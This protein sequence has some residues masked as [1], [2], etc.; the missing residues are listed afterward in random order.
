[1][2]LASNIIWGILLITP[3]VIKNNLLVRHTGYTNNKY[4]IGKKFFNCCFLTDVLAQ[5]D[6]YSNK[7]INPKV[8][9]S[10]YTQSKHFIEIYTKDYC[11]Y[12]DRAIDLFNKKNVSFTEINLSEHPELKDR[13]IDRSHRKTVPQ[14]FI[15]HQHIGGCDDLYE[16]ESAGKLDLLLS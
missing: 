7:K 3:L 13:M 9:V 6:L 1:M 5:C 10:E 14:I 12:C 15:D 4:F 16:L 8:S 2:K 11:P